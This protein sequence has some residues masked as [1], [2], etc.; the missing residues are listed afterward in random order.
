M[1]EYKRR[2]LE[3]EREIEREIAI[4]AANAAWAEMIIK[5]QDTCNEEKRRVGGAP[6]TAAPELK[7]DNAKK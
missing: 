4:A 5:N 2:F 7:F 1:Q 3:R 6:H